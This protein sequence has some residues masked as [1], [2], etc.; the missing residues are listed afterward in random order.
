ML[1]NYLLASLPNYY[2]RKNREFIQPPY[3]IVSRKKEKK[4]TILLF[5]KFNHLANR[6]RRLR[7]SLSSFDTIQERTSTEY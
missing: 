3:R 2:N 1:I 4:N 7:R 6:H 5:N